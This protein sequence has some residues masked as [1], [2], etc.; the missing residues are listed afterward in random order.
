[1][2]TLKKFDLTGRL[3]IIT[4]GAGL[5]GIQHS[6]ALIEANAEI[7]ILD[8]DR[9]SL[10]KAASHFLKKYN[11]KICMIVTDITKEKSLSRAKAKVLKKFNRYPNI[12]INNAAID[13][14]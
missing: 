7:I 13:A 8:N 10:K 2:N 12:L 9:D 3:A 4:G 5:L 14:K 1:M 6:E 11:K